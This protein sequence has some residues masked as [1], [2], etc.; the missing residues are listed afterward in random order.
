MRVAICMAR[1]AQMADQN[2]NTIFG[3]QG[4]GPDKPSQ[5]EGEDIR[6]LPGAD[7]PTDLGVN[8]EDRESGGFHGGRRERPSTA[9]DMNNPRTGP[10]G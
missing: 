3:D 8:D 5:A 7:E 10:V 9:D 4:T 1:E 2:H 6:D